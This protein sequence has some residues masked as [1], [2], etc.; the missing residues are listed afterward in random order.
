[1]KRMA[2]LALIL[3]ACASAPREDPG[4]Y[5]RATYEG[6]TVDQVRDATL[7]AFADVHR[8]VNSPR[9]TEDGRVVAEY[10]AS[11]ILEYEVTFSELDGAVAAEVR[12]ENQVVCR[13]GSRKSVVREPIDTRVPIGLEGGRTERVPRSVAFGRPA[14]SPSGT[15]CGTPMRVSPRMQP[16]AIQAAI[17]AALESVETTIG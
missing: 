17:R 3:G 16:P 15:E 5:A 14:L 13:G 7:R 1:M 6:Y 4:R 10:S 11:S 2:V 8:F 9:V 12:A